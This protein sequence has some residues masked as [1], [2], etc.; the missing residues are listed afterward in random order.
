MNPQ[1]IAY[2]TIA[3][4]VELP[5]HVQAIISKIELIPPPNVKITLSMAVK[6]KKGQLIIITGASGVGK[7][8]IANELIRLKPHLKKIITET[9]RPPRPGEIHGIDYHFRST[10]EFLSLHQSGYYA[11]INEYRPG[12]FKGTASHHFEKIIKGES[13][14]WL[15]DQVRATDFHTKLNLD[16]KLLGQIKQ[17]TTTIL[18]KVSDPKIIEHRYLQRESKVDLKFFKERLKR[19]LEEQAKLESLF[20]HI[21]VND[22]PLEETIAQITALISPRQKTKKPSN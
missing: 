16:Q 11:E 18:L 2:E 21:V 15:V 8:V 7:T 12:E 9:N 3:L 13:F 4:T 5:C 22:G 6:S 20:D 19:D 17:L 14:V 10:E 1:P